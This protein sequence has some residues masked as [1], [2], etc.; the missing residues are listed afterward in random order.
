MWLN[1]NGNFQAPGIRC[2]FFNSYLFSVL[3]RS[4]QNQ[5]I[6][7]LFLYSGVSFCVVCM[8]LLFMS[9]SACIPRGQ[10]SELELNR[11]V[12]D[13]IIYDFLFC[14]RLNFAEMQRM[15]Y[16]TNGFLVF[17]VDSFSALIVKVTQTEKNE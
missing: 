3:W 16:A 6:Q 12:D 9:A 13:E 15:I 8:L 7:W 10:I 17:V 1:F 4:D 11:F 2:L 14:L 5:Q